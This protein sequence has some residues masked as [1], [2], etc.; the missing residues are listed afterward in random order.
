MAMGTESLA[1]RSAQWH[2][3]AFSQEA[4]QRAPRTD[5]S[6]QPPNGRDCEDFLQMGIDAFH[7][8][9]RADQTIRAEIYRG[10][11]GDQ[12]ELLDRVARMCA[13]W[14]AP[15]PIAA[16]WIAEAALQGFEPANV[17]E[18]YECVREMKAIVAAGQAQPSEIARTLPGPVTAA[19]DE[20]LREHRHGETAEFI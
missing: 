3:D 12:H 16:R 9:I 7:W 18:F 13:D 11:S 19:R 20:A 4:G 17:A 15:I 8:L 5:S 2:V 6:Q 1:L 14:L 10:E